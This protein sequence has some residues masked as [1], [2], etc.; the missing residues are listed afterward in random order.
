WGSLKI[1]PRVHFD[2]NDIYDYQYRLANAFSL[3]DRSTKISS[4]DKD[5]I[6]GFDKVLQATNVS[7]GRRAKYLFHLKTI[8]ENIGLPFE[9]ANRKDIENFIGSWL[10]TQ[11]YKAQTRNDY[12]IILKRFYKFLRTGSVDREEPFPVEVRF[13]KSTIK[14]NE[15]ELPEFL[16]PRDVE[17]MI[18]VSSNQRDRAMLSVGFEAGLR[19]SELLLLSIGDAS[20]DDM[21]AVI[22]VRHGKTGSR[23]V[24]L[25]SSAPVLAQF[26]ETHPR[27]HDPS[28][29]LW[30]TE[31]TNHRYKRMSW[32]AWSRRLKQIASDARLPKR[33]IHN[34]MLRHGSATESA[35][36]LKDSELKVRYGWSM[37]SKMAAVYVHLSS[38]DLDAKL[39]Q[40]YSGRELRPTKPEFSPIKCIRCGENNTPATRFC[41]KCGSPLNPDEIEKSRLEPQMIQNK[42]DL[43]E[44]TVSQMISNG[45]KLENRK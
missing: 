31:A 35:K 28:A 20:F 45:K 33:K 7:I 12:V 18:K 44:K 19:A 5:L 10:Y 37:T 41:Q 39:S 26:I 17:S 8:G 6:R 1:A 40:A 30:P 23:R 32:L 24:R 27:K 4:R 3:I 25:I 29:P 2:E 43:L 13:L 15:R 11:G 36:I 42:L 16:T 38:Q 34:H 21:G 9:S 22:T 14:A